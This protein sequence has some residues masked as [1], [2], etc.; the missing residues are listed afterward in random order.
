M[1]E[2]LKKLGGWAG[3]LTALS[4]VIASLGLAWV[5]IENG[6]AL[7]MAVA[8]YAGNTEP[9]LPTLAFPWFAFAVPA[10]LAAVSFVASFR[11]PLVSWLS[12]LV[13]LGAVAVDVQYLLALVDAT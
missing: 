7:S 10:G 2:A 5:F 9:A 8:I 11:W 3:R 13:A 6:P 1:V 12:A 4:T